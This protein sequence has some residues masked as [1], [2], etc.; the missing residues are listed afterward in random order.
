MI[1]TA[2][3]RVNDSSSSTSNRDRVSSSGRSTDSIA[4][5]TTP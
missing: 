4:R 5:V 3:D 1:G 2:P